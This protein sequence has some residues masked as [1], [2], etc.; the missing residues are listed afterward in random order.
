MSCEILE[1]LLEETD[2]SM[3]NIKD[4]DCDI[5]KL[6]ESDKAKNIIN[7]IKQSKCHCTF[8]CPKHMDVLY[9]KKFYPKLMKKLVNSYFSS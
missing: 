8:E 1:T 2:T 4:F 9:N 6:L 3:G 7:Y 5:Q